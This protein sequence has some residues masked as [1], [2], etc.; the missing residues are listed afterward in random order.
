VRNSWPDDAA[1]DDEMRGI[2]GGVT[3][4]KIESSKEA[5]PPPAATLLSDPDDTDPHVVTERLLLPD[6]TTFLCNSIKSSRALA[7][8]IGRP[9][10]GGI[11]A[12][13]I[14]SPVV[15]V[16]VVGSA[17][18]PSSSLRA[19]VLLVVLLRENH[20]RGGRARSPADSDTPRGR[21][22]LSDEVL[23]RSS[24]PFG[25]ASSLL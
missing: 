19:L 20:N 15:V 17:E 21:R 12:E 7:D 11:G 6:A 9:S 22:T 13:M 10:N 18:S 24:S 25:S 2:D 23:E 3:G 16:V 8:F 14:I 4:R 5:M 1:D